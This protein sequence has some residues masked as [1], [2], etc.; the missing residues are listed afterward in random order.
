M[1]DFLIRLDEQI[2]F[3]INQ[4]MHVSIFHGLMP[5]WRS[6]YFWIPMY[7]FLL[8]F[9]VINF[10]KRGWILLLSAGLTVGFSDFVSS[11]LIKK[12]IKRER[13]C[14]N[15]E[16]KPHVRLLVRC[17]SGYS[18][19]SSHASNHFA[20][21]IFLIQT[22]LW[23]PTTHKIG[24]GW[25]SKRRLLIYLLVFWAASIAFA[26]VYV[27]VH[28]PFDVLCGALLGIFIGLLAA[29]LFRQVAADY[30]ILLFREEK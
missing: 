19:T 6:A 10:Q 9:L 27:G 7:L 5:Y 18:F 26:Q 17:G 25:L 13:P 3:F 12:N 11:D 21:A 16:I 24:Q 22:L 23:L 29:F 15:V 4:K 14:Q 30:Q 20:L 2:F 28:Y 1:L 8:T